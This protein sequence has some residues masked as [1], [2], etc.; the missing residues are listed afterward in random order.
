MLRIY[1]WTRCHLWPQGACVLL[2]SCTLWKRR[3][4]SGRSTTM[5]RLRA[6]SSDPT[7]PSLSPAHTLELLQM[8]QVQTIQF[9][10]RVWERGTK[11]RQ[12]GRDHSADW[13]FLNKRC[14]AALVNSGPAHQSSTSVISRTCNKVLF[15]RSTLMFNHYFTHCAWIILLLAI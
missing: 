11:R 2:Q 5:G 12:Q 13:R 15:V 6:L 4:V 14:D 9:Q 8:D 7:S 1:W 3:Q 10:E